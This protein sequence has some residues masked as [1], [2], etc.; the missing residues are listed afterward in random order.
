[1]TTFSDNFNRADSTNL[2]AN[3]VE[4]SGD[5]S[6]I[7]NQLSPGTTG[8]TVVLRTATAMA[9]NDNWAQTTIAATTAVSQGVWCRGDTTL[10]NGYLLRN[11]G[12]NWALFK[13]VSGAFTSIGTYAATAA[14]GD[15]AKV[16]AIGSTIK[17]F[18][19]GTERISV[20]D[21]AVTTGTNVGIRSEANT[22]LRFDDFSAADASV[23]VSGDAA[24]AATATFS[25]TGVRSTGGDAA[26]TTTATLSASGLRAA[27]G[28]AA[29]AATA[30]LTASG[31]RTTSGNTG[32]TAAA[33]LAADGT[34]TTSTGSA[35]AASAA[36]AASGTVTTSGDASLTATAGL[37]ASG[38]RSTA[39]D[40]A[41]AAAAVFTADGQHE[42]TAGASLAAIAALAAAGTTALVGA[43][44]LTATATLTASG[45]TRSAHDDVDITVGAPYG[46]WAAAQPHGGPWPTGSPH[47]TDW[48]VAAP[49]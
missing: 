8:G 11:N 14:A 40:A 5:W 13:V 19:N 31:V 25:A 37:T 21:T 15:V 27:V 1:M 43:A 26:V 7:S 47:S 36:L 23:S 41:L 18:I 2:G 12:S 45:T 32:L 30:S 4:V 17:A 9:S 38:Q 33:T 44:G 20:T 10:D 42:A 46:P 22:G 48:E 6:I 24:L 35:L 29:L 16:Q 3:W 49:W 39:G 28:N 34:R